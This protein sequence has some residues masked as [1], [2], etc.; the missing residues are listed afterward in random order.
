MRDKR[1][2]DAMS[3]DALLARLDE[4]TAEVAQLVAKQ[5]RVTHEVDAR[6]LPAAQGKPGILSWLKKRYRLSHRAA[7]R[8]VEL[9]RLLDKRPTL[10]KVLSAGSVNVEQVEAIGAAVTRLAGEPDVTADAVDRAEAALVE[11]AGM[12]APQ[13]L[14]S[15]GKRILADVAP[16]LADRVDA[17]ILARQ[18]PRGQAA[19]SFQL[20]A[21]G[22]GLVRCT[23]WLEVEGAAIVQA[24]IDPRHVLRREQPSG[25]G[26]DQLTG[27]DGA[28]AAVAPADPDDRTPGQ[29]R[30]DA[31]VEVCRLALSRSEVPVNGRD[32]RRVPGPN[33]SDLVGNELGIVQTDSS[34]PL[35]ATRTQQRAWDTV[36]LRGV[37]DSADQLEFD[38]SHQPIAGQL[39]RALA[40]H[41]KRCTFPTCDRPAQWNDAQHVNHRVDRGTTT[42]ISANA[43]LCRRH[44]RIVQ[45]RH[46]TIRLAA[47]SYREFAPY[48]TLDDVYHRPR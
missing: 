44:R 37:T 36:I 32:W 24:A 12:F 8:L 4:L 46:W 15:R 10:E 21:V 19:R 39:L 34:E 29:R 42:W 47:N 25:R 2:V 45:R 26:G 20:T 22:D 16:E 13:T 3:D 38:R 6:G 17:R 35:I 27:F 33:P 48:A 18:K 40:L 1:T 7:K 28:D 14:K 30:A 41:G 31:L 9:G 43:P 5:A 23:G 11:Q